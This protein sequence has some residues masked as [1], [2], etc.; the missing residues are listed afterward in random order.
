MKRPAASMASDDTISIASTIMKEVDSMSPMDQRLGFQRLKR[1]LAQHPKA[2]EQWQSITQLPNRGHQK[3]EKKKAFLFSFLHGQSKDNEV[4][5]PSFWNTVKEAIGEIEDTHKGQ[6]ISR[7]RL[8]TL[9][10]FS[11][12][13]ERIENG[14]M[15]TMC[16]TNGR[17][18]YY[19][20]EQHHAS[21]AIKRVKVG[22]SSQKGITGEQ[23]GQAD[24]NFEDMN[25]SDMQLV[26]SSSS[27][28]SQ[29]PTP[30]KKK[31]ASK[32][33]QNSIL[34]KIAKAQ[35]KG[36]VLQQKIKIS[37]GK[38]YLAQQLNWPQQAPQRSGFHQEGCDCGQDWPE[39]HC[40]QVD[41]WHGWGH[42][43]FTTYLEVIWE[44]RWGIVMPL[45]QACFWAKLPLE[46]SLLLSQV[47]FSQVCFQAKLVML[48]SQVCF[49]PNLWASSIV[50]PWASLLLSKT[51]DVSAKVWGVVMS[52]DGCLTTQK[53]A[54][55]CLNHIFHRDTCTWHK[56]ALSWFSKI[57]DKK[58][59]W[60][61]HTLPLGKQHWRG[62]L[63]RQS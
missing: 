6:W 12:A 35:N 21:K 60:I 41:E 14:E 49:E 13:S 22:M 43:I 61:C 32:A 5:G 34:S 19:Y 48:G 18:L 57:R 9:V 3:N 16:D 59:P 17:P 1:A 11:E 27:N 55:T 56:L 31:P 29:K 53:C 42:Q 47:S 26:P 51:C 37:K 25:V 44:G 30:I 15:E 45:S 62:S 24:A 2:S 58:H 38:K 8:E 10:G 63:R 52:E 20:S 46:P 33:S 54:T 23:A 39:G 4:F 50:V 40:H 28:S 36:L 7:G